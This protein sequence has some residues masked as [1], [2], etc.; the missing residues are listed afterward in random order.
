MPQEKHQRQQRI[1]PDQ[2]EIARRLF[3]RDRLRTKKILAF[4]S[5]RFFVALNLFNVCCF[6]ICWELILC[7]MGICQFDERV[8]ESFQVKYKAKTN[9]LG[10]KYIREIQVN[11]QGGVSDKII[12]EDFVPVFNDRDL[13]MKV[14]KDFIL[15]KDLRVRL[16]N[17]EPSYRL[18]N[19]SP[20][21]FL[22]CMSIL[23]TF[24]GYSFNLNQQATTLPGLSFFNLIFLTAL[25]CI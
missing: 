21:L 25:F 19:A 17:A 24:I 8:P 4:K 10:Y 6:F 20:L 7:F 14:G 16:G 9:N 5:S 2:D 12:V 3:L 23:V 13:G 22:A 1:P 15:Q 11:W 18:S